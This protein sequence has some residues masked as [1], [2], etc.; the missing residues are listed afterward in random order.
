MYHV[1]WLQSALDDAGQN[2]VIANL[3]M[4]HLKKCVAVSSGQS[5]AKTST[6]GPV[7]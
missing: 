1:E 4:H 2:E 5:P 3:A 7:M 6:A